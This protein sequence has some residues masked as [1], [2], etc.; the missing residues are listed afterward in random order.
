MTSGS[1][2]RLR[3]PRK[4]LWIAVC[5]QVPLAFGLTSAIGIIWTT[6]AF[7][8]APSLLGGAQQLRN[9]DLP[10]ALGVVGYLVGGYTRLPT[11]AERILEDAA[12][13]WDVALWILPILIV[14]VAITPTVASSPS[15]LQLLTA[16]LLSF[17]LCFGG[18]LVPS[19]LLAT[20]FQKALTEIFIVIFILSIML[21]LLVSSP[22]LV[23]KLTKKCGE[24]FKWSGLGGLEG[25]DYSRIGE[26]PSQS[27]FL[28]EAAP[29]QAR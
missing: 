4:N 25:G 6:I 29:T 22:V 24:R 27:F 2:R 28:N 1:G 26:A 9:P 8:G 17:A 10:G 20:A 15:P 3:T 21:V 23:W 13:I 16:F 12:P 19:A 11:D 7:L 18:V 5:V 14:L